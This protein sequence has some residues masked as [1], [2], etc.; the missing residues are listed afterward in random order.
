MF[1][2]RS[3]RRF[4]LGQLVLVDTL[5]ADGLS[6]P[7]TV[8]RVLDAAHKFALQDDVVA[9]ALGAFKKEMASCPTGTL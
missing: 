5:A 8:E 7:V 4:E 6:G 2:D 1:D 3:Q 9:W